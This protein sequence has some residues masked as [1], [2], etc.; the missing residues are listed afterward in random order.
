MYRDIAA[1]RENIAISIVDFTRAL[2]LHAKQ[3]FV[4]FSKE[5][6]KR[7]LQDRAALDRET[8]VQEFE[9]IKDDDLRAAEMIKKQLRIGR[10]AAGAN[11]QGLDADQ[12]DFEI[13]QRRRMGIADPFLVE[14]DATA[15]AAAAAAEDFG[16]S[17]DTG[18]EEVGYDMDQGAEGD[19]Y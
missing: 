3:Q 9:S 11:I 16:L 12:F 19:N 8:I 13:E 5:A 15:A 4:R 14:G 6:I 1:D 18:V 7:I 10:W 2:M 17:V